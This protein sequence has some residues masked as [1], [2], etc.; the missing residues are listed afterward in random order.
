MRSPIYNV[1]YLMIPKS[2]S[3]TIRDRLFNAHL[4]FRVL[5]GTTDQ[6]RAAMANDFVFTFLREPTD[7]FVSGVNTVLHRLTPLARAKYFGTEE[8]PDDAIDGC[9]VVHCCDGCGCG[10]VVVVVVCASHGCALFAWPLPSVVAPP[11]TTTPCTAT[12]EKHHN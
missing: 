7:R 1:S 4:G 9:V 11:T 10:A 2:S 8:P 3:S 12:T 6:K 5:K